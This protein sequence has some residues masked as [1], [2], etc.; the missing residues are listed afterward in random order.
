MSQDSLNAYWNAHWVRKWIT[1]W[2]APWI[3]YLLDSLWAVCLPFQAGSCSLS[4]PLHIGFNIRLLIRFHIVLTIGIHIVL[5]MDGGDPIEFGFTLLLITYCNSHWM[6]QPMTYCYC[7]LAHL[8]AGPRLP[9]QKGPESWLV[10][11]HPLHT[12]LYIG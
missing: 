8:C 11:H 2:I 4:H 1:D 7:I 9:I 3:I 5:P 12:G 6:Q 10:H